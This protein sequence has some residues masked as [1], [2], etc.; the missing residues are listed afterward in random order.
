MGWNWREHLHWNL[1]V[2]YWNL[3]QILISTRQKQYFEQR[4][5]LQQNLQMTGSKSCSDVL[6]IIGQYPKEYRSLDILSLLDLSANV[7]ECDSACPKGK[8]PIF[9][10]CS[11]HIAPVIRN[12]VEDLG[13]LTKCLNIFCSFSFSDKENKLSNKRWRNTSS[14]LKH[15]C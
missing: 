15:S 11:S 9:C 12:I 14:T 4:R 10:P 5:R 1:V 2:R 13:L 6:G 7:Q 8:H 3:S